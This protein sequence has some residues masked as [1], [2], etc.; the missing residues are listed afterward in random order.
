MGGDR[1][2][3]ALIR[4]G[5]TGEGCLIEASLFETALC[6]G[7]IHAASYLASGEAPRAEGAS[8]PSLTPY[9]AFETARSML[10]NFQRIRSKRTRRSC[11]APRTDISPATGPSAASAGML[12]TRQY[13]KSRLSRKTVSTHSPVMARRKRRSASEKQF[14]KPGSNIARQPFFPDGSRSFE[15]MDRL[16]IVMDGHASL[17]RQYR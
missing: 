8:H 10:N 4:R 12:P 2:L 7:S 6:W 14:H 9:G 17:W 13:M 11:T 5:R 3:A 15:E 1:H 16:S